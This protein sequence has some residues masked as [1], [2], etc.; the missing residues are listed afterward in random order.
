MKKCELDNEIL[1]KCFLQFVLSCPFYFNI[2]NSQFF[3]LVEIELAFI[4]YYYMLIRNIL[5]LHLTHLKIVF[6]SY[7]SIY[8]EKI[9]YFHRTELE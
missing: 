9:F 3:N 6:P 2:N 1:E 4:I 5:F 8:V 7:F